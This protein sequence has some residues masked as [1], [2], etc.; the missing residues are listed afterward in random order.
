VS[1]IPAALPL[2]LAAC[3][4]AGCV[5]RTLRIRS[6]P[7]GLEVTMNGR[8]QGTTPIDVPFSFYGTV[9]LETP[10]TDLDEDGWPEVRRSVALVELTEPW[11]QWFPLDFFSDNLLPWTVRDDHEALITPPVHPPP[12]GE[13]GDLRREAEAVKIRAERTRVEAEMEAGAGEPAKPAPAP[14]PAKDPA[15][16]GGAGKERDTR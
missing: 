11:Y 12:T 5:E 3:S 14:A 4:A 2:L 9:R 13:A 6:E 16:D 1:R 10:A 7:P 8:P 15:P